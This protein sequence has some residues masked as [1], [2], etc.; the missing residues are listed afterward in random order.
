MKGL[1]FPIFIL[2]Q[3]LQFKKNKH[4]QSAG[5]YVRMI[6]RSNNQ[7]QSVGFYDRKWE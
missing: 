4:V 2:E 1:T 5:V 3:I 7:Q 6:S